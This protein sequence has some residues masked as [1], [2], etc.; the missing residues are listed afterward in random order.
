MVSNKDYFIRFFISKFKS[1]VKYIAQQIPQTT[2]ITED[3]I[4]KALVKTYILKWTTDLP[5]NVYS[6]MTESDL[7]II[8]DKFK[9]GYNTLISLS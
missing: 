5:D 3:M 4:I 1:K 2:P 8:T 6:N 9:E 7:K